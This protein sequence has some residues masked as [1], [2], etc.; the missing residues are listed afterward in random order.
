MTKMVVHGASAFGTKVGCKV[1]TQHRNKAQ[2]LYDLGT[3]L[4]TMKTARNSIQPT[5]LGLVLALAVLALSLQAATVTIDGSQA[6]QVIDGFGANINHWS[7]NEIGPVL[8]ALVDQA[9]LSVFRVLHDSVDWDMCNGDSVYSNADWELMWD[10]IAYLNQKGITNGVSV[11]FMGLPPPSLVTSPSPSFLI[12]GLELEWAQMAASPIIYAR[13]NRHLQFNLMEP[14]NEP[15]MMGGV[16]HIHLTLDQQL[17][18]LHHMSQ[19]LDASGLSDIR[20][21]GP[22]LG[23]T[24]SSWISA[25]LNDPILMAKVGHIGIHCYNDNFGGPSTGVYSLLRQSSYTNLNFWMTEYNGWCSSCEG[26]GS[27]DNSWSFARDSVNYLLNHLGNGASAAM[28]FTGCDTWMDYLKAWSYWGLFAVDDTNAI[29]KT[30]TPRKGFYT[31]SQVSKYVRPGARR[32]ALS[33]ST[34]PFNLLG[35]YHPDSG[36]VVLTGVNPGG[37][38]DLAGSM[39]S[40]PAVS[41]FD[42]YYTSSSVNLTPGGSVPVSNGVFATAI[43]ADC[44]FTL[45]SPRAVS[46]VLANPPEG[47]SYITGASALLQARAITSTGAISNVAFYVGAT[48]LGDA[49]AAPYSLVWSNVAAGAYDLTAWATNSFGNSAVSPAVQVVVRPVPAFQIFQATVSDNVVSL[50][51]ESE[52]GRTYR[53]QSK[54]NLGKTYW[55]DMAPDILAAGPTTRVTKPVSGRASCLYRVQ[56]VR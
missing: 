18:A 46:V 44:V 7:T 4:F 32:I 8:D 1:R 25:W 52:P 33:G 54:N 5:L 30:F 15:D 40:L 26:G 55:Q 31:L 21:V 51:W 45:V 10:V 43:P 23:F 41:N 22:D 19:L 38:T 3:L 16:D 13:N 49:L 53:L 56:L 29:P 34:Y 27:G 6:Y 36:Q 37:A 47:A 50:A 14:D 48:K 12:P 9:G 28:I 2:A 24:S 35:F 11:N 20:F 39:V 17:T 42:L